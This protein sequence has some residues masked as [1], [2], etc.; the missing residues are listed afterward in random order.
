[1]KLI[2][3]RHGQTNYNV[4]KLVNYDPKVNVFLTQQGI[5][6]AELVGKQLKSEEINAVY[7]SELPR[8]HQTAKI[9]APEANLIIDARL[10][11]INNGFEGKLV[12]EYKAQRDQSQD[13]YTYRFDKNSESPQDVYNR[14]ADFIK[15][16]REQK[17][18]TVLVV[19]SAHP[20]RH[21]YNILDCHDPATTLSEYIPNAA[22]LIRE[23]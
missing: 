4:K 12:S 13:P 21:F 8:T 10:N 18:N 3:V 7:V 16:L 20:W 15:Y 11:D 23:I 6:E 2:I 22:V 5:S 14:V 17:H 19:T 1:M 9:I